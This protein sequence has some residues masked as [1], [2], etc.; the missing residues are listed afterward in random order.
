MSKKLLLL[1]SAL[2]VCVLALSACNN[3]GVPDGMVSVT[4]EG[5]PFILYVPEEWSDNRASGISSA[6]FGLNVIASARYYT[7]E[8]ASVTLDGYIA[9]YL[10]DCKA[11]YA[12]F[13]FTRKDSTLGKDTPAVRI[14]YDFSTNDTTTT[15]AIQYFALHGGDVIMLSFYCESKSFA[16]YSDDFEEIR[17]EFVLAE[18]SVRNDNETD[19]KTPSGMKLASGEGINYVFYAPST[20]V[21]DLSDEHSY[22]YYPESGRPNVSVTAYTPDDIMTA[23]QYFE[24]CEEDYKKNISGYEFIGSAER[25]VA[26]RDAVS[27]TYKAVYG[28]VELRVMQ[29][30]FVYNDL[31]YSITYTAHADRFDAHLSDVESMLNEFRF[32]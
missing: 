11:R 16:D 1:I 8:D 2:L 5:E 6:H 9:D 20:W 13:S 29:T 25:T 12:D 18:K 28:G 27:Y 4:L 17:R 3:D 10:D 15:K 22:A 24:L 32:R 7:P 19:K 31:L 21:T 30:V 23:E 26:E 14:E